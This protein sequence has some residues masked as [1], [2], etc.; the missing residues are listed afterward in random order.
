MIFVDTNVIS[1]TLKKAPDPAV[2]AWLV[3]NDAELALP[4]VTIAEIAFG[5][6]KIRPD[7]RADRLEQG[8]SRWRHRFADRIFG[9]TEEAAL[10]YGE[11]MAAAT[12]QGR[13]M[14]APDGMIAAIARVNGGRLATRNLS[15]FGTTSLELISPWDF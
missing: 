1:E 2:L 3:R 6:Q 11:I 9:L 4:T 5:I 10:A 7:E 8:L 13:G 15:D 14:S 12:R